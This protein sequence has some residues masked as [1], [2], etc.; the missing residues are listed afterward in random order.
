[1]V[2]LKDKIAVL[3]LG[4]VGLPFAAALAHV[5]YRVIASDIDKEKI[6]LLMKEKIPFY[7]P[8]LKET[9]EKNKDRI[10]Y[11]NDNS[12]AIRNSD[13]VFV[14]VGT[15]I[16]NGEDPDFTQVDQ[17]AEEIGKNL[18]KG[19]LIIFK[20]TLVVGTTEERILSKLE[21]ISNLKA[22]RDFY[23]AYC[24]E[25][26]IEGLALYE[27]YTLPKIVGG[28][29]KE[30]SLKAEKILRKLGGP[31]NI[32]SSSRVAEMCKLV[33]NLYRATNI[34]FANELGAVCEQ[35]GI[36]MFEVA[37][38][39][40][41]SYPRT[42]IFKP[43]LG[44]DG[45]CLSK[46]PQIFKYSAL[47]NNVRTPVTDGTILQN[48]LATLRVVGMAKEF[49]LK[50]NLDKINLALIGLAFKGFPETDDLRGSP[51]I[52]IL[53]A[54]KKE[55]VAMNSVKLYDP[56]VRKF[57]NYDLSNS[58]TEAVENANV[59]LFL[60]NHPKIM[61]LEFEHIIDKISKPAF[62]LDAWGNI[63]HSEIPEGINYFRIG[64]GN[65]FLKD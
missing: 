25:R 10:E 3:G 54:L 62:I 21:L 52:K 39:V 17:V 64:K 2:D 7:E 11:T 42:Q 59:I 15:P 28:I 41:N 38:A 5:G 13:V 33:D 36:N 49:I 65:N 18:R 37:S 26:T 43:G 50:N 61:N 55:N 30:S 40:N 57:L 29:N 45:P 58:I 34:A 48:K 8:G 27:I 12:Y 22:G 1:M 44:A 31:V 14:T 24:P 56:L 9:L 63:N 60:N 6:D 16:N 23:L 32:V 20:S 53:D 46:D 47:K 35:I 4:Y 19:Q 51:A